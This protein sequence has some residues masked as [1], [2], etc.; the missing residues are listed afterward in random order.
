MAGN[1]G[2]IKW[3]RRIWGRREEEEKREK[4]AMK[5]EMFDNNSSWEEKEKLMKIYVIM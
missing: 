1:N 2:G 4:L 3:G 5:R